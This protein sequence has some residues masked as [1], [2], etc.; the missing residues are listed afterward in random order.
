MPQLTGPGCTQVAA[1]C[2]ALALSL[3]GPTQAQLLADDSVGGPVF[4]NT[5]YYAGPGGYQEVLYEDL[6]SGERC[7]PTLPRTSWQRRS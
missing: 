4:N 2:L 5:P 7:R 6:M 1:I 3:P